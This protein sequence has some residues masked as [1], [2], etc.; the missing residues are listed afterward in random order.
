[1]AR[2]TPPNP[3]SLVETQDERGGWSG[4][5]RKEEFDEQELVVAAVLAELLSPLSL[6]TSQDS[7]YFA[8]GSS[9]SIVNVYKRDEFL[10]GKRKPLKTI[11]NLTTEMG[12]MKFN[13]DG[14]ILAISSG[15]DRNG[16]RLVHVLSFTVYQN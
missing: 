7:S 5:T 8:T 15:R 10:G 13:H 2:R 14:Q 12:Q 11:E 4:H 6:C 9:S 3:Y 1:M 16:M